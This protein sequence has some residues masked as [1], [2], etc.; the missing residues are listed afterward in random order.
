MNFK[1]ENILVVD[2]N[3]DMLDLVQRQLK[4]FNYRT[5]KAS[6]VSEAI[7]VLK[8]SDISL[9]ISDVNM[10]DVNCSSISFCTV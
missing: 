4:T 6:S 5:Y 9:L 2:D 3:N 10:P 7:E 1:K 8:H